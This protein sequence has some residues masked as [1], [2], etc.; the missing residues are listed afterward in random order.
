MKARSV[1][2]AIATVAAIGIPATAANA[3]IPAI[4]FGNPIPVVTLGQDC[5]VA[6]VNLTASSDG[7]YRGYI[8][9]SCFN[10]EEQIYYVQR[11]PSVNGRV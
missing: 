5:Q 6:T 8:Y 9:V 1:V 10:P 11:S 7:T 3:A 2:V 4:A